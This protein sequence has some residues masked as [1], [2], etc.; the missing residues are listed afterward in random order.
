MA[1]QGIR[2]AEVFFSP[3][4][5][6]RRGLDVQ[7]IAAAVRAG[8]TW[9]SGIEI[10]LV[11]D[12][13][14]DYGPEAE[15]VT[16]EQIRDGRELGIVGIG[17]GG[18]E[19]QFALG[20]FRALFETARAMGFHTD[21]HAGEAAG[22]E[23]ICNKAGVCL[24]AACGCAVPVCDLTRVEA[25]TSQATYFILSEAEQG[26]A[27]RSAAVGSRSLAA[28]EAAYPAYPHGW[29]GCWMD[30]G[31]PIPTWDALS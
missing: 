8:L 29:S 14:R 4:L 22:A 3:S 9:V 25:Q 30:Y 27:R 23:S 5:F 18:L 12:L 24:K 26:H 10:A 28:D 17:I 19:H 20:P 1:G 31:R 11:A 6:S 13:V 16:L 21:A 7:G 2:Y 15:M